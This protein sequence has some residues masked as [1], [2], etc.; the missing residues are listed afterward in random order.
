MVT[1]ASLTPESNWKATLVLS[2]SET[3]NAQR[4]AKHVKAAAGEQNSPGRNRS[5]ALQHATR[6]L[7]WIPAVV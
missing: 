5:P 3:Q 1:N 7:I 4:N 2:T 6:W